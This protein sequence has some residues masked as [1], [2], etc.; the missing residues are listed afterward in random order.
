M[1]GAKLFAGLPASADGS[2]ATPAVKDLLAAHIAAMND[3][4]PPRLL[5][6]FT[7]HGV[8]TVM[9]LRSRAT[10][11]TSVAPRLVRT[12]SSAVPTRCASR[13]S[14]RSTARSP[15][16]RYRKAGA[17]G[18][19]VVRLEGSKIAHVWAVEASSPVG[20]K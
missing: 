17:K 8:I 18:F 10:T 3:R 7:P 11:L 5:S 12:S 13:A 9:G 1:D 15:W 14:L 16:A 20:M 19:F 6:T 2:S 4:D